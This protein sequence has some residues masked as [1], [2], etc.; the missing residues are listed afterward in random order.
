[1]TGPSVVVLEG[2]HCTHCLSQAVEE[3]GK[4]LVVAG[5]VGE[6]QRLEVMVCG[7]VL[8]VGSG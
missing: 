1:M 3:E 8:V 2:S 4:L 7:R 5:L 6:A